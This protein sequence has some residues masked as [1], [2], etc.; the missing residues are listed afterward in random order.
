MG[1]PLDHR[2]DRHPLAPGPRPPGGQQRRH[3]LHP[4]AGQPGARPAGD[5][6]TILGV[7][8]GLRPLL[9]GESDETSRLSREHAVVTPGARPGARRRRQV[10]DL[11]G[12][13]RGRRRRRRRRAA[14]RVPASRDGAPA[15]GRARTGGTRARR[16]PQLA[17]GSGCRRTPSSGCCTAT[18]TASATSWSSARR[19]P[20]AGPAATGAPD[21]LAAEVVHAVTA[22]GALHLDDV[23]TRRTRVSIE[24]AH[25][26]VE[27]A[28]RGRRADGAA[29]L[30]W[31]GSA[32]RA[33]SSTT[34]RGW[35]PS[36]S[37]SGC[38]TTAPP[39]RRGS[40]RRTCGPAVLS[41]RDPWSGGT[42]GRTWAGRGRPGS[43]RADVA[44]HE[45]GAALPLGL[46]HGD[47]RA[48]R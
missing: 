39:T 22:E 11:P 6:A 44:A 23:L 24:T 32:P 19:R 47:P 35:R 38:P 34:R 27:S 17:A 46:A 28:P 36:G 7:Y 8:A 43:L 30:G 29:L 26:G 10:H 16:A 1:R 15:A 48:P 21:Y 41:A 40:A 18:A 45:H 2:H 14:R 13:G 9:A 42:T 4:R 3:R 5:A 12:H 20:G 31:D 25:R 33:R 37:R